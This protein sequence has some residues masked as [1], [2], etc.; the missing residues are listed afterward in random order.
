[1][2]VRNARGET[3]LRTNRRKSID[4]ESENLHGRQVAALFRRKIH[5]RLNAASPRFAGLA[6]IPRENG[7]ALRIGLQSNMGSSIA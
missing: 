2:R 1:M 7:D 4:R 3:P 5:K 6:T